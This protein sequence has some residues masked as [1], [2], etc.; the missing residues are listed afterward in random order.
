MGRLETSEDFKVSEKNPP[1]KD[2]DIVYVQSTKFN[3]VN[4]G[5]STITEPISSIV[6]AVTLFKLLD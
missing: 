5:L 3:K 6:T 4:K 1:L 2:R